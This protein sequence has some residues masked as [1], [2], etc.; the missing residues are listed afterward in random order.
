MERVGVRGVVRTR[1]GKDGAATV[2]DD[3]ANAIE[4]VG[5]GDEG[6]AGMAREGFRNGDEGDVERFGAERRGGIV[7]GSVEWE[8]EE[9]RR[10]DDD[11]LWIGERRGGGDARDEWSDLER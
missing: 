7:D 8:E 11:E 1:A 10:C 9:R 5:R 4:G 3:A 2:G 6:D